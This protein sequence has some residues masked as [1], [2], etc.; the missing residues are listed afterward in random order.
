MTTIKLKIDKEEFKKKLGMETKVI[1]NI[2]PAE[3]ADVL[4]D[5]LETLEGDERLDAKAI[6]NLPK[7]IIN[8]GGIQRIDQALDTNIEAPT[9]GQTLT[10]N[11]NTNQWENTDGSPGGGGTWGS[12]TGT[13]SD[14]TDLQSALDDKANDAD[15][16]HKTG[17]E[18]IDGAKNILAS[19]WNF[20]QNF[21]FFGKTRTTDGAGYQLQ[22]IAGDAKGESE[23]GGAM[24][25]GAGNA[26]PT[27]IEG[28]GGSF[29]TLGGNSR[30][31]AD[32][33][34]NTQLGGSSQDGRGG[35]SINRGGQSNGAGVAGE[36]RIEGADGASG[37]Q[38]GGHAGA[39]GG[40]PSGAGLWGR[41]YIRTQATFRAFFNNDSMTA[42][43]NISIPDN[44]GVMALEGYVDAGLLLKADDSTVVHNTGD[45]SIG[46]HKYFTSGIYDSPGSNT[47]S[48]DA[49]G[50]TLVDDQGDVTLLWNEY[51]TLRDYL[52]GLDSVLDTSLLTA[53]R[54]YKLPDND[55]TIA[56]LD[57]VIGQEFETV[58]K[59]LKSYPYDITYDVDD[60]IDFI[61]YDTGS[62]TITKTFGY[63][64][65]DVTSITLSGS[66]PGG[67]ELV[68]SLVYSSGNLTNVTY[69]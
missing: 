56:L 12:I 29:S 41:F 66:T 9:D 24:Q 40:V 55:G 28:T 14:Q 58:S 32:G 69:A 19:F 49:S 47:R 11:A 17:A 26:D 36:G 3:E 38:D 39:I 20:A 2:L 50:R 27:A 60:N 64:S 44:D 1:N 10:F 57:N 53:S 59:N 35:H 51:I 46:G 34:D 22:I 42:D 8:S 25:L 4:R 54:N 68:K 63:T 13:L 62:G 33:G 18:D 65:G 30:G 67:I 15:V 48:I 31:S 43:R 45:E 52:T 6:K 16:V 5:K 23:S 61:D 7:A 21:S 37:D